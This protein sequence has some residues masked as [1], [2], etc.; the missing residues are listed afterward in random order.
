VPSSQ[1]PMQERT[2]NMLILQIVS[3]EPAELRL[4]CQETILRGS[5]LPGLNRFRRS[6]RFGI[7]MAYNMLEDS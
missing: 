7:R 4:E 3:L 5:V 2:L 6:L 1:F